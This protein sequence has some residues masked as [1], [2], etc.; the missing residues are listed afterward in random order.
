MLPSCFRVSTTYSVSHLQRVAGSSVPSK[1]LPGTC[2]LGLPE[3][4]LFLLCLH[5]LKLA[6]AHFVDAAVFLGTNFFP[7]SSSSSLL[8]KCQRSPLGSLL[9]N[10]GFLA[11][12]RHGKVFSFSSPLLLS[13]HS[14][15]PKQ[16]RLWASFDCFSGI[17]SRRDGDTTTLLAFCTFIA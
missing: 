11:G 10:F 8:M 17:F 5:A 1:K 6:S 14:P 3:K 12:F 13:V 4:C 7:R 9:L 15:M 2:F 16:I